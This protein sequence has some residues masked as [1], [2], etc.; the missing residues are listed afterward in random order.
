MNVGVSVIIT[1]Y[2]RKPEIVARAVKSVL[3][4]TYK[5]IE[6]IVVDD[7]PSNYEYRDE[8]K[9]RIIKLDGSINYIQHEINKGAC[10]AR[11]TGI[12]AA[13]GG[14]VAFL[15]DDDEWLPE[16]I[17]KQIRL[18]DD[19]EV[20]LVFCRQYIIT[21][22][23]RRVAKSKIYRGMVYDYIM[24]ENFIGSTSFVVCRKSVLDEIGGF[25]EKMEA[26]QDRELWT[27]ITEKYKVDYVDEPL[28]NYYDHNEERITNNSIKKIKGYIRLNELNKSYL[29][30]HRKTYSVR[31]L[32]MIPY[33]RNVDKKLAFKILFKAQ[34]I[35]PFN[36]YETA[37]ALYSLVR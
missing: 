26:A 12:K 25:D 10:A 34:R 24:R 9:N 20:A 3:E 23:E 27:R 5:N 18:F 4:Q 37:K 35:Y 14:L 33:Y 7:S 13:K 11:N 21:D 29:E 2:K 30:K 6:I 19:T 15:D 1:T 17:E 28:V 32:R 36:F 8:V 31:L 22:T 16:K